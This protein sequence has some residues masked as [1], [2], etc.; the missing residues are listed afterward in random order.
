MDTKKR[1]LLRNG[2]WFA[3]GASAMLLAS[4]FAASA[5]FN[6]AFLRPRRKRN[7]T[8]DL[9]E[10][11]PEV[12][13]TT[14]TVAFWSQD[15]IQL[16]ALLL[17]P[18]DAN[19]AAIIVCHG[20][21]H[22]KYSGVRFVQYLLRSGFTLLL[23][24]FRNHG[25]SQGWITTYG[26]YEKYDLMAAIHFLRNGAG[27]RGRIGVLG[28]SM[29]AS[30][31]ILTAAESNEIHAVVADSPFASLRT[32]TTQWALQTTR[33]P[34]FLVLPPLLLAYLWLRVLFRCR[35]N[36][37]EPARRVRDIH[38]PLFLIHG[39]SDQKIPPSHS[40][41]ILENASVPTEL[42]IDA[43]AGHLG[44]YLKNP[45]EYQERVSSFFRKNL[46]NGIT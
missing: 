7:Q 4:S 14:R 42:W 5:Y 40:R 28:A 43:E 24:D 44:V 31:A 33:M 3:G 23:I 15:G 22:D 12:S 46:L 20:L 11:T 45:Q 13:Y 1:S 39:G 6:Y 37:V 17:E 9:S 10:F 2:L 41:D 32:M 19:G 36:D 27:I 34:E 18:V 38:C 29:G 35:V 21:A 8:S 25:E 16:S 26:F 30:I